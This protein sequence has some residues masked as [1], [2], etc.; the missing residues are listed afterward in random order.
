MEVKNMFVDFAS[1]LTVKKVY[2]TNRL[3][4]SPIGVTTHRHNRSG[5]AIILK[6]KGKTIYTNGG[7]VLLS[8]SL[9]P[10]I[11][12]KSSNYSWICEEAGECLLI[13]FEADS[14]ENELI[15]YEITDNSEIVN[16]FSKI[17]KSLN[18]QQPY[19]QLECLN[20]LYGIL[21]FL[22]KSRTKEPT[23][24]KKHTTLHPA[25]KYISENYFDSSITNT[26]LAELC[27]ISTVYFRKTFESVYGVPP[28]KYLHN[29]RI[30]KAKS[31]LKSDFESIEQVALS[32]GYNSIYHFS[33]MFKQ[34]IGL[35]PSEYAKASRI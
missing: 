4:N 27:G 29:F 23:H 12:P 20:L 16:A 21:L 28:I 14:E 19:H 34:Y 22:A 10:I 32:V 35:T 24:P 7:K 30:E 6:L 15:S 1:N 18:K 11:L 25:I 9:H 3:T 31:I 2:S 5:W 26:S 8:D 33:K 17:E 13:E